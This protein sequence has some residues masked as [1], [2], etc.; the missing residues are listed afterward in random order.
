[1]DL[2]AHGCKGG[3][4]A[5]VTDCTGFGVAWGKLFLAGYERD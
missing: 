3:L 4:G 1:M 5:V 2:S